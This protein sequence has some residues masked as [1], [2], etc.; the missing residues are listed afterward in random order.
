MFIV[1][2]GEDILISQTNFVLI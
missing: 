2:G 1:L